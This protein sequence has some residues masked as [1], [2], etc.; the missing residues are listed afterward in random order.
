MTGGTDPDAE[1][2]P[3]TAAASFF[4]GPPG[5]SGDAD[6]SVSRNGESDDAEDGD[7]AAAM[8]AVGDEDAMTD[9]ESGEAVSVDAD[10]WPG[11]VPPE[12]EE[13]VEQ[14]RQA[15]DAMPPK[16]RGML[17]YYRKEGPAKPLDAHFAGG[18]DGDRTS[19]Y[20]H[21]RTL[22]THGYIEHVGR[23]YYDYRLSDLVEEEYGRQPD[24]E[25]LDALV[26]AV[27]DTFVK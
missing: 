18:G 19:A 6:A 27:E 21:N 20:A 13:L 7:V 24:A 2:D 16:T 8:A 4:E 3:A 12:G 15:I 11:E 25:E 26:A 9:G 14:L 10:P 5:G 17:R 1:S 22:R 23:G